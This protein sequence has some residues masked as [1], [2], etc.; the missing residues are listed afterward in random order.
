MQQRAVSLDVL[1]GLAIVGMVLSSTIGAG[2]PAWM[3]HAQEPPPDFAF[4]PE[5]SGLTWVDVVFPLFLFAMGAAFPFSIGW[6]LEKGEHWKQIVGDIVKRGVKLAFFS[7]Y[8]QHFYP[9]MLQPGGGWYAWG[10][11]VFAFILLFPMFMRIPYDLSPFLKRCIQMGA[12]VIGIVMLLTVKDEGPAGFSLTV[13]NPILMILANM[14]LQGGLLYLVTYRRRT[15]RMAVCLVIVALYIGVAAGGEWQ[16]ALAE[17]T[18][19]PGVYRLEYVFYLLIVL[20]GSMA[21]EWVRESLTGKHGQNPIVLMRKLCEMGFLLLLLGWCVGPFQ[22]GI[23]KDPPTLAYL[24]VTGGIGF[25]V[26][27]VFYLV[28]D[29]LHCR[30]W[31][32]PLSMSGQNPMIAY[33]ACDLL[34][35]PLLNGLGLL[36]PFVSFCATNVWLALFQGVFLTSLVVCIT[37]FFTRINWFWRT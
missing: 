31:F 26:L 30:R 16:Q 20:P 14:A 23:K 18:P 3:H 27:D 34:I 17:W 22:G 5:I 21:G 2:L 25:L 10:W 8:V 36:N 33:V 13:N 24:F 11:A 15:L 6:R 1:R 29:H 35:Y 7:V 4:H 19:L 28:C 37:M 9:Y 12:Y 32:R